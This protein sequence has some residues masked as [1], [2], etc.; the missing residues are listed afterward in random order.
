[1]AYGHADLLGR[2]LAELRRSFPVVLVDNGRQAEVEALA[3]HVQAR[4][5]CPARNLGFAGGVNAAL[6]HVDAGRDVLLLNSD[7]VIAPEGVLGLQAALHGP[8]RR[9][10]AVA[11]LLRRPDGRAER[12]SWPLPSPWAVWAGALGLQDALTRRR[13]L[14]GAVLMLNGAALAEI[15]PFDERFFMYA[16]E[17]DWQLRAMRAGWR[18]EACPDVQAQ[19]VGGASFRDSRPRRVLFHGSAELFARKWYGGAG[20]ALFRSGSVVAAGRRALFAGDE[21]ARREHLQDV[22]LLI[23]GPTSRLDDVVDELAAGAG[24]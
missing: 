24:H 3:R 12:V 2:S 21:A 1:M 8:G 5:V 13:F 19:H 17:A 14:S 16:E 18:V 11:P 15:G 6:G 4:Y 20:V 23:R 7:A 10:A 9:I 22:R